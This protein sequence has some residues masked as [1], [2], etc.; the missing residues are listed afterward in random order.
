MALEYRTTDPEELTAFAH[1]IAAAFSE[2]VADPDD[3]AL[4]TGTLEPDRCF[5]AVEDGRIVGTTGVYTLRTIVPGGAEVA[6]AGVTTVGVLPTHRRRGIMTELMTRAMAQARERGEPFTSLYA[7]E[8]S[9]YGRLG[10]A[11]AT[12][13][14]QDD[15]D[16]S[17]SAF[18][19]YEPHGGAA[20]V[21]RDDAVGP[22]LDVYR[23]AMAERPGALVMDEEDMGWT[24]FEREPDKPKH[25]Y[26]VHRDD[27]GVPDAV[28]R[29]RVKHRWPRS[30]PTVELKV[31]KV[32][33]TT[34]QAHA[35][36]WRY[37]FDVDLVAHVRTIGSRAPDDPLRW[38]LREPRAMRATVTDGLLARPIDVTGTLAARRYAADGRV[39]VAIHDGTAFGSSGTV[40]IDVTDGVAEVTTADAAVD[41][42]CDVRAIGATYLGGTT[43]R[44]LQGAGLV[45]EERAG[46]V[47]TLDA[48][49]A[50][51][52]APWAPM[53]F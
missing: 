31:S 39:V 27:E 13:E 28:A 35:D 33:A 2:P 24:C 37:L 17:R 32:F 53:D 34:P 1:A 51:D 26:L 10:Y 11:P 43:W 30:L 3:L 8:A 15:I 52:V 47:A 18:F 20:L 40:A 14:W 29:Y 12:W 48:M 7:A 19:A 36:I 38:L 22:F 4:D 5:V 25:N 9:I 45:R 49:F 16:A 46:A 42:A 41:V 21:P 44:D 6:T 23:R 50:T